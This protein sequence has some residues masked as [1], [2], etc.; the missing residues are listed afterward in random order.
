M[1]R[2]SAESSRPR[3]ALQTLVILAQSAV[4]PEYGSD[5]PFCYQLVNI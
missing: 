4:G 5:H 1:L 3:I 2:D